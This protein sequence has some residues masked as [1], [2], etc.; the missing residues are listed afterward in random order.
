MKLL[1]YMFFSSELVQAT[2]Q[3]CPTFYD[4]AYDETVHSQC[5]TFTACFPAGQSVPP[6]HGLSCLASKVISSV[7]WRG[8]LP[9]GAS[10]SSLVSPQKKSSPYILKK[11]T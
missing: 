9:V 7:Y 8:I 11:S 3:L 6:G 1:F 10:A 4:F 5:G 2:R